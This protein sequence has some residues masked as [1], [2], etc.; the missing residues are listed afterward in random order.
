VLGRDTESD[1]VID[2]EMASRSHARI[3]PSVRGWIVEDLDSTNG[4]RVNGFRVAAQ[5][6]SDGDHVSIGATTFL[7]DAS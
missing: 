1:V 2:D 6:L 5:H 4:T 7:F 3:R